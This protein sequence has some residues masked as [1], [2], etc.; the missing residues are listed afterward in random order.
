MFVRKICLSAIAA[1]LLLAGCGTDPLAQDFAAPKLGTLK[2]EAEAFR[3]RI[4]CPV[5]GN[6]SGISGFGFR[7]GAGSLKEIPAKLEG[8]LLKAEVKALCADTD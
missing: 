1:I 6:L 7:F 3:A 4:S 5:S 2:V 8:G